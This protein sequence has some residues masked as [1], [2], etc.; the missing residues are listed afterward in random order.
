MISADH[1]GLMSLLYLY[2]NFSKTRCVVMQYMCG[3]FG[4]F[5]RR[6]NI[7]LIN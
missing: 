4:N 2:C 6:D 5:T 7:L 3:D 1:T